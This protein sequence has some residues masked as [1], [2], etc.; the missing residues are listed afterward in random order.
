MSTY[1]NTESITL[2]PGEFKA[3]RFVDDDGIEHDFIVSIPAGASVVSVS[4]ITDDGAVS[5]PVWEQS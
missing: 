4:V 2:N 1:M 3:A 5:A